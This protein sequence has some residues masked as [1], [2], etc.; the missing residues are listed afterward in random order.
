MYKSLV[1]VHKIV[2]HDYFLDDMSITDLCI[3]TKY[4]DYCEVGS[5]MQTRQIMLSVLKPYLKKKDMTA[6]ELLP[7]P[8]DD[9]EKL[10]HTTEIT[11]E[12]IE[13]YNKAKKQF[14]EQMKKAEK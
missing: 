4:L 3:A 7:L 2:S 1:I 13:W 8:I 14:E 9:D 6:A 5:W 12:E 11:N 10:N